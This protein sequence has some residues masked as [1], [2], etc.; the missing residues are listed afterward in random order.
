MRLPSREQRRARQGTAIMTRSRCTRMT[1]TWSMWQTCAT[2]GSWRNRCR[3]RGE[4]EN[5]AGAWCRQGF[6]GS[7]LHRRSGMP[8][9]RIIR[10]RWPGL[11]PYRAATW[12]GA[13]P[14][15]TARRAACAA[16]V[17][18]PLTALLARRTPALLGPVCRGNP[19]TAGAPCR[20][21]TGCARPIRLA[22]PRPRGGIRHHLL[23]I[24]ELD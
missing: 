21:R 10:R 11:M 23:G 14:A 18:R 13:M 20:P 17:G 3:S 22:R 8:A 19:R 4:N 2:C 12:A 7:G 15:R 5:P 6:G 1:P 16:S 9:L 24:A